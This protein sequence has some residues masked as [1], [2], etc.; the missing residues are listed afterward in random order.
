M[1]N[2]INSKFNDGEIEGQ[3]KTKNSNFVD[4]NEHDDICVFIE[5]VNIETV[6]NINV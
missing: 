1:E 3:V 2:T 6:I 4:N 5:K